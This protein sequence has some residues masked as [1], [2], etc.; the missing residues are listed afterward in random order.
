M[1]AGPAVTLITGGCRS[2]KSRRALEIAAP[3]SNRLFIATAEACDEEMAARI[4]THRAER[5]ADFRTIEA[6]LD[7]AAALMGVTDPGGV[8]VIDCLTTWIA[9]LMHHGRL[10][11]DSCQEIEDLLRAL[12][13]PPCHVVIVSNEVGLGLVPETALGRSF[14]DRAGWLNQ[15]VASLAQRVILMVAGLPVIVKGEEETE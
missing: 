1:K 6:P 4:A 12:R 7:P 10:T 13:H 14:R 2:G 8:A 9:N 5:G 3:F 11:N 15:S